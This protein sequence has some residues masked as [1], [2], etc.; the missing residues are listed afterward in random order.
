MGLVIS[1]RI[2]L[3]GV[4]LVIG[5]SY[6]AWRQTN[7]TADARNYVVT[8]SSPKGWDEVPRGPQTLF[9]YK[10]P[11]TGNLLRGAQNQMIAEYNPTP[12]LD[13]PGLVKYYLERTEDGLRDWTAVPAG[14]V[15]ADNVRFH[16]LRRER[17]G[18]VILS[19]FGVR[20]N[21]TMIV[22]LSAS[23]ANTKGFDSVGAPFL[24]Q[25][26]ETISFTLAPKLEDSG[27]RGI[28]AVR[29]ASP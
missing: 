9:L 17:P 5:A 27:L 23:D 10:D 13:G 21:T 14:S 25:Y 28:P 3:V 7:L 22:S 19:A 11:E 16:L 6:Y 2:A 24:K 26:L 1:H 8:Y 4:V 20:G 29:R 18:K 12:E 15:Q